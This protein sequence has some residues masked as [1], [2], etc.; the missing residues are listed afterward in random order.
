MYF[1]NK[2][3]LP[4]GIMLHHFHDNKKHKV[5]QG[6]ISKDQLKKVINF[7]GRK[8]IINAEE[9]L[10]KFK[11][12]KITNKDVVLT[13]D[14]CRKSQ[15]DIA[16]EVLEEQKIKCFLF[17]Y[18]SLLTNKPDMLEVY[19]DFRTNCFDNVNLFYRTF[20]N[21][22]ENDTEFFF[23]KKKNLIKKIKK[24]YKFYS[25]E[26]IKFRLIRDNYLKR[27]KYDEIMYKMMKERNFDFN[28]KVKDLVMN[29][30]E[31]L[32]FKA[33]GHT[34]GLHSH[35]H[36]TNI[37]N[38]NQKQQFNEYRTNKKI[39]TKKLNINS[40]KIQCMS[41]PNGRYSSKT[42]SVLSKLKI[43]IGFAANFEKLK[44]REKFLRTK[45]YKE[46]KFKIPREDVV[47]VIKR[48]K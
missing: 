30:R 41:H 40:D 19:R 48:I 8:N 38:L 1:N 20:Y 24:K 18:S 23:K 16:L 34:I 46:Y 13:I 31:I 15:F 44:K 25:I 7:I 11:E 14:D 37:N 28:R 42:F 3:L 33:L 29:K 21:F 39:F 43:I 45:F 6:S 32:K 9:F 10:I 17:I 35:T 27:K 4:H 2:N 36:P 12:K 5:E 47:N 26:D 22:L